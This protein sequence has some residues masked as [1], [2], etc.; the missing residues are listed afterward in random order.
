MQYD[1]GTFPGGVTV[2]L[3]I[4]DLSFLV[5]IQAGDYRAGRFR[6]SFILSFHILI[7]PI[8]CIDIGE[9]YLI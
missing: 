1:L 3:K 7:L 2:T 4:L 5:R 9:R 8:F 6:P